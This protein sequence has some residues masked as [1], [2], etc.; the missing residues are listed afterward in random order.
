MA[1]QGIRPRPLA[2]LFV[3]ILCVALGLALVLAI[4]AQ[5]N[6]L[7]EAG[8]LGSLFAADQ[9][10]SRQAWLALGGAV[11]ACF[12]LSAVALRWAAP[13]HDPL[14]L[15]AVFMLS[16]LGLILLVRLSPEVAAARRQ[17][18]LAGMA[19]RQAGFILAGLAV[20]VAAAWLTRPSLLAR[21]AR[22]RYFY[23]LLAVLLILATG[24]FG[25]EINGR[26]LWIPLGPLTLQTV[27]IAKI[28]VV[29]FAAGYF[30]E[31]RAYLKST[32]GDRTAHMARVQVLGPFLATV[33]FCLLPIFFQGDLG[34]T[35][36]LTLLMVVTF[37]MGGGRGWW[38]LAALGAVAAVAAVAYQAGWPSMVRTRL[39]M[40]LAPF[41][42]SEVLSRAHWSVASGGL[43]GM[44][45]GQGFSAKIPVVQSD[46]S[47]VVVCEELGLAGGL[48]VLGFYAL[49]VWRGL[50]AAARQPDA[51]RSLLAGGLVAM[52]AIQALI[53]IGGNV[54]LLPLTG[55]TLP[56]VSYG[57]S[58]LLVGFAVMG[59]LIKLS[60]YPGK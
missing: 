2:I 19:G 52:L 47:F 7:P 30:A 57:G 51:Y 31:R 22:R 58:S 24:L 43:L 18:H 34:P 44:G 42:Y 46:F 45:L 25:R 10:G 14:I 17:A 26:R 54:G 11:L 15:A 49:I 12:C 4:L 13:G 56:L 37:Y 53:I 3:A 36:L 48:A 39:D 33:G 29:L 59:V 40:W 27:E 1:D 55:I 60:S 21:L 32:P 9:Q 41:A 5:Q 6:R 8:P 23:A 16:G 38:A 20:M 28:L 50:A 35:L